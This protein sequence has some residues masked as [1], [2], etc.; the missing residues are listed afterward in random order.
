MSRA[1]V[2]DDAPEGPPI[3]PPRRPL[4]EGVPNYV[5][6]RGLRLLR[7]ERTALEKERASIN[8]SK[9]DESERKRRLTVVNTQ[10]AALAER[11]SNARVVRPDTIDTT[12]ARF[13]AI[14]TVRGDNGERTFQIVGVD[15][16][17][18]EDGRVAFVA[19]IARAVLGKAV[20]DIIEL[21]TPQGTETLT[22]CEI[23][24]ED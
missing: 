8:A 6:P 14:I 2:K 24:K 3:V 10:L 16:A 9:E 19:P 17:D 22:I 15:E 1:F 21:S 12:A 18:A 13:G 4:P 11:I 7:D 23:S 5:T 20:G